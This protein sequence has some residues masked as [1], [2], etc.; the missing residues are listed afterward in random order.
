[1]VETGEL[2]KHLLAYV[3]GSRILEGLSGRSITLSYAGTGRVRHIYV[4]DEM[5]FSVRASD[6][7]PIPQPPAARL[8]LEYTDHWVVVT[9]D[10]WAFASKGRNVPAKHVMFMPPG[11]RAGAEVVV[12]GRDHSP[13]ALGTLLLSPAEVKSV[14]RGY[15]VR[16]RK[17][18]IPGAEDRRLQRQHQKPPS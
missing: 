17:G 3:Y 5:Y 4:D 1:M 6:G 2:V 14:S 18:L 10:A 7:Y 12:V 16:T 11:L 13:A 9:D 15:A 8:L